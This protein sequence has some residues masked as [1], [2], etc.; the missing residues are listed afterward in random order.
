MEREIARD[1]ERIRPRW[2]EAERNHSIIQSLGQ[3][4]RGPNASEII[5]FQ[6]NAFDVSTVLTIRLDN[7]GVTHCIN[8]PI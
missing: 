8:Q 3:F 6:T 4:G 1:V 5:N 2:V 7:P